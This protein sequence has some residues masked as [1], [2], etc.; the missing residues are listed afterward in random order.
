MP[1]R[2]VQLVVPIVDWHAIEDRVCT[3]K[4]SFAT[5]DD[6]RRA[7]S[8]TVRRVHDDGI[9]V[10]PC[11]FHTGHWHIG[12]PPDLAG[13]RRIAAALRARAAEHDRAS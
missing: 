6:A 12:H 11:P 7:R 1:R 4:R 3:R 10:Y 9:R 8:I 5:R 2:D 13:L